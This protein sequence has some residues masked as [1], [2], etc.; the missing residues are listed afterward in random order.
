MSIPSAQLAQVSAISQI[1]G[2]V[3]G[4][5][6]S[7]YGAAT[8]KANLRG[9]TAVAEANARIS[10]TN[11]RMANVNARISELGAQSALR[12][13][14]QEVGRLTLQ[15]GQLKSRQRVTMAANGIDISQGN[16]AEIFASTDLMKQV[17]ADTIQANAMRTAWGYRTEAMNAKAQAIGA[18]TQSMNFRNQALASQ[19]A[20]SAISPIGGAASSLLSGAGSVASS[21][22]QY[23]QA[24]QDTRPTLDDFGAAQGFW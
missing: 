20:G 5:I 21:W 4:S 16:A 18:G 22:Y 17:D 11:I 23:S 10:D 7:F 2:A 14:Q 24:S 9:Q 3:S 13:G 19:A 1:G 8:Q 6:G 15:A 12:Q